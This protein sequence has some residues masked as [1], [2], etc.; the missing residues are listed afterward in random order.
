MDLWNSVLSLLWKQPFHAFHHS[1]QLWIFL[2]PKRSD[3]VGGGVIMLNIRRN[4]QHVQRG[5]GLFNSS[6]AGK[7]DQPVDIRHP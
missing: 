3:F 5:A 1:E 6:P 2:D 4:P 7:I